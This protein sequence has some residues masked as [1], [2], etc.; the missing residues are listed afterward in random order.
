M[1]FDLTG[2]PPS[3][4]EIHRFVNDKSPVAHETVV[5]RLLASRAFG[6]HWARHWLDLVGYADGI[7]ASNNVFAEYSWRYR[8]YVIDSLNDNKPFNRFIQEQVAGDL[9]PYATFQERA[10]NLT[11]TGFLVLHDVDIVEA[12][13]AKLHVDVIDQQVAKIGKAFL[14]MTLACARCHDHKFDPILQSD[15]YAIGGIFHS[16]SSIYKLPNG[17]W[18]NVTVVELPETESQ[19]AERLKRAAQHTENIGELETELDQAKL[20]KEE[21]DKIIEDHP[22]DAS[23]EEKMAH[24][25]LVKERDELAERITWLNHAIVHVKW[26]PPLVPRIHGVR[27]AEHPS[28]MKITIRGNPR[29]LG[30]EVPRGFLQIASDSAP[31]IPA[32]ESGRR[33]LAEW[34]TSD[35]N[36]C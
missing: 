18:S 23:D 10:S 21:L 31:Q 27:D 24:E 28:D 4:E 25:N 20:R 32:S 16:T 9:L 22:E 36:P 15:Y 13:K 14:G 6:E 17:V 35:N 29:A 3:V 11:A 34:I 12:D 2:L 30:D 19:Q 7:G 1:S 8:D 5:Q 26:M 33:Q